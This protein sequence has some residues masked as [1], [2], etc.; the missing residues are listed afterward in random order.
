MDNRHNWEMCGDDE[1]RALRDCLPF[2]LGAQV[3]IGDITSYAAGFRRLP[4][5][6]TDARSSFCPSGICQDRAS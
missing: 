3:I 5:S 1:G 6:A 4:S 2:H